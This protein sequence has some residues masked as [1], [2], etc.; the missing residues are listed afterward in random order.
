MAKL[1]RDVMTPDPACCSAET[2]LD[3][4]A[5]MMADNDC[6]E[7][8]IVDSSAHPI[9]VIT[10]RDIVC[11]TLAQGRNPMELTARDCMTQ[12]AVAVALEASLEDCCATLEEHRIR[13][14]PI[15]DAR[16][17]IRGIV[18]QADIARSGPARMTSDV[19]REVS[20]PTGRAAHA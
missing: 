17:E 12:P 4:V 15:V 18:S 5:K 2:P 13:R 10:D 9:G 1:A 20:R 8:P 16:G 19:V 7:I 6:G 14:V 3:Q 11:R